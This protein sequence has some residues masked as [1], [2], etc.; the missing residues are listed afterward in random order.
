MKSTLSSRQ[1]INCVQ[2]WVPVSTT[3]TRKPV[4]YGLQIN[5]YKVEE[6]FS[7]QII[8]LLKIFDDKD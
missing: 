5:Y 8:P 1:T 6:I 4:N 3:T 2:N 7:F